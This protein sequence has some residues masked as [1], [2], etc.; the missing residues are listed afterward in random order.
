MNIYTYPTA[1]L[2]TYGECDWTG[3]RWQKWPN[4]LDLGFTTAHV[5][6]LIQ[7]ATDKELFGGDSKDNPMIWAPIH[8][9]RTL[10]QLQAK[11]AI[12]PLMSLFTEDDDWITEELPVVY[13]L[14]GIK[15]IPTLAEYLGN[16]SHGVY[17]RVSA[18]YSLERIGNTYPEARIACVLA[19]TRQLEKFVHN[20]PELNGFLISYLVDL[21]AIESLPIIKQAYNEDCVD[22]TIMGDLENVEIKLGLREYRS[23]PPSHLSL[24]EKYGLTPAQQTPLKIGRNEPCPCGSGKKYKKC[25]LNLMNS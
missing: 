15:A 23:K 1:Q 13:G 24:A 4:Y 11:A 9:W 5:T 6:E 17:P 16:Q 7:M 3:F 18:V 20:D 10:A 8:A 2:L 19:L 25:C 21:K 12:T 22:C 14:I